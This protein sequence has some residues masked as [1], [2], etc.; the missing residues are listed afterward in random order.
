MRRSLRSASAIRVA[1]AVTITIPSGM[2]PI[3]LNNMSSLSRIETFERQKSRRNR[4]P[5]VFNR[6]GLLFS[7]RPSH[8]PGNSLFSHPIF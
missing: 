6:V 4:T 8:R 7:E 3:M 5:A 1:R 2:N